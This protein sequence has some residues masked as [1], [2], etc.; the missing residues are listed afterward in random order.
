MDRV[1][2]TR[3]MLGITSMQ[4]CCV[5]DATDEEILKH[6]NRNNPS[7]TINGWGIV[8]RDEK[9]GALPVPCDDHSDRLHIVV[10]C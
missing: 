10:L 2:T 8:V 5:K 6:C 4:V 3:R 1:V 9:D 7:G